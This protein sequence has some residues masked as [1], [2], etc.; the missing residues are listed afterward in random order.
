[1]ETE[2]GEK[3]RQLVVALLESRPRAAIG[4][5]VTVRFTAHKYIN[6]R[7]NSFYVKELSRTKNLLTLHENY[8][9]ITVEEPFI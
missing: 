9:K 5:E 1:M 6:Y 7:L 3:L 4:G 8:S 2:E